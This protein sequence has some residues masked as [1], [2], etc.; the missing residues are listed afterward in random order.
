MRS[1]WRDGARVLCTGSAGF[2]GSHLVDHLLT[3]TRCEVVVLDRLSGSGDLGRLPA[4]DCWQRERGRVRFAYHDLKAPIGPGLLDRLGNF[5]AIF[6]LAA[7]SHVDT[8]IADPL[9]FVMDNVVGSTHLLLAASRSLLRPGGLFFNFSTDEV[10]GTVLPGERPRDEYDAWRPSNPYSG[11]KVGQTA[12]GVAFH[13][14]Y[15]L[16]VVTTYCWDM[17]TRIFSERG[18]LACDDVKADDRVWTLG[19][20]ESMQLVPVR[21][22]LRFAGPPE[23]VQIKTRKVSQMLTPNHRVLL[24][25]SVGSPRRW[26]GIEE[27]PAETLVGSSERVRIP[28]NG[29]W[30]GTIAKFPD[31]YDPAWL[32]EVMGWYVSEGF[33]V[34]SPRG[35]RGDCRFGAA[36]VWQVE[37]LVELLERVARWKISKS[38]IVA[39]ALRQKHVRLYDKRLAEI[40][41]TAGAGAENKIIPEFIKQAPVD[42]LKIFWTAAMLGD[43]SHL[44]VPGNEVY[45]TVSSRLAEDMCEIGMKIGYSVRVQSRATWNPKRTKLGRSFIVRFRVPTADVDATTVS[46]VPYQGDVWCVRV[47][48]GRLFI[49]RDGIVSLTGNSMNVFG[50]RQHVEKYVPKLIRAI[51][52]GETVTIH[53]GKG[54]QPGSRTWMYAGNTAHALAHLCDVAKPGES[55]SIVQPEEEHDNLEM[56]HRVADILGKPH[57]FKMEMGDV[58]R[59]G[60]DS[61]YSI[62]GDRLAA[63]GWKPPRTFDEALEATVKWTANHREWIGL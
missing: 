28:I 57:I 46:R 29:R 56:A 45:Y 49:E 14:T 23:M 41:F 61:R 13:R 10:F 33:V 19:D 59:P 17:A 62:A 31:E 5:D 35:L 54:G 55:Y 16:P 7:S 25:R 22:V 8:S 2:I 36:T 42:I 48:T 18:F 34:K 43:G 15:G 63:T 21:E 12:M 26:G 6:H 44:G 30:K 1:D 50:E 4:L 52:L 47:P 38:D 3:Q 20:D 51:L 40:L 27:A 9:L 24:R 58:S 37:L 39:R 53:L 11:S 32:A 60:Y